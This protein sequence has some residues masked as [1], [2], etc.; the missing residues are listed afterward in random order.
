MVWENNSE[1]VEPY[2]KN[3]Q[4]IIMKEANLFPR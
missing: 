1:V 4:Q 3:Q 2:E